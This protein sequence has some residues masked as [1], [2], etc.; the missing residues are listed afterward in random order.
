LTEDLRSDL[1]RAQ[2]ISVLEEALCIE[3]VLADDLSEVLNDLL[4]ESALTLIGLASSINGLGAS[5]ANDGI[6]ILLE[7]LG[8]EDLVDAVRELSPL[9]VS[10]LLWC[11]EHLAEHL[12]LAVRDRHLGHVESDAELRGRDVAR[13]QSVKITEE[14]SDAD[15]LLLREATHAR[16]DIIDVTWR[17]AHD[18]SVAHTSL[19][20]WVVVGA[21]VEALGHSKE[22]IG[23]INILAEV[24]VVNFVDIALVHVTSENELSDGLRSGHSQ[25]VEHTKELSF[26]HVT[27][28][29]DVVVLEARLEVDALVLDSSSVFLKNLLDLWVVV[30]LV[31]VLS[32]S[33]KSV[34]GSDG[35]YTGRGSLVDALDSE[36]LIHVVTECCVPEEALG[37]ISLV[38]LGES[39]ELIV[40]QSEVELRQDRFKLWAGNAAL[41][42]LVKVLEEVSDSHTLHDDGSLESILNVRRIVRDVNV[43]L[44]E[45][46]VDHINLSSVFFEESADLLGTDTDFLE[47]LGLG[48]LGL[49]GWEH[50]LWA[51]N[52]LAEVEVV[53]LLS[54]ATV[55]VTTDDQV[56]HLLARWHDV[57]SLEHTEELL[58]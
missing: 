44:H 35:W 36:G 4:A 12:E 1:E 25:E 10:S 13:P 51:I 30:S 18:L 14:L 50:V 23:A 8:G 54:V 11:L 6:D 2:G 17:V 16:Q 40:G 39:L 56:V 42:K 22:L 58:G 5:L 57:E 41:A 31:E 28:L 46:V 52:V 47:C 33:Q 38:L 3:A 21:V 34:V 9:D 19:R 7:A 45:A 53:N 55:T 20:L 24:N 32:A 26:G 49:V 15:A 37:I 27:V 48:S 43:G 29:G